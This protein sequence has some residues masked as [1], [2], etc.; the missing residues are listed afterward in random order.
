MNRMSLN[1]TVRA[2][3][4]LGVVACLALGTMLAHGAERAPARK[5]A[6]STPAPAAE[7][8]ARVIV[9]FRSDST[10]MRALAARP[11]SGP[12]PQQ[13]QALSARLGM[14]LRDGRELGARSQ[15]VFASGMSSAALAARLA[16]QADVEYAV[17]DGRQRALAAPNDPRYPA[18]QSTTPAV[19]QWY[20]R[21]YDP[22]TVSAINA[23]TAWAITTGSANVVVAMLDTGIRPEHPDLQG[24]LYPGYDFIHDA[25]TASDGDGRDADP[26][27]PGD[28]VTSNDVANGVPGCTND[29]IGPSSWHGTQTSGLVGAATNN[30]VGMASIGRN[31]MLLP[32]RVLGKCGGYD[33]DIQDA[34]RWA[35]GIA[36]TGVPANAHPAKVVN[37]SL[38]S[39]GACNA[40]YQDV[41]NQLTSLGVVVVAAAGNDGLAV[42]TPANC[43][44]VIAVAGA[45]HSGTKVGYSDLGPEVA[46]SA[47]AGN[48]VNSAGTCLYPLLTT[49]NTGTFNGPV[50]SIYTDGDNHISVGTSFSSPLVAGTAALM[51]SANPGLTPAQVRA[52]LAGSARPFPASDA[53]PIQRVTGGPLVPVSACEAPTSTA[54]DYECY[55]TTST[56]GA[57]LLNA[58]AAVTWAVLTP[59]ISVS[60]TSAQAGS[61][62]TLSDAGSQ[63][64]GGTTITGHQWEITGDTGLASFSG[65]TNA[66]TATL[67]L[68]AAGTV[69][70]SSTITDSVGR[71]S[72][73][74]ATINVAEPSGGGGGGGAFDPLWL[75]GVM[76]AAFVLSWSGRS[77]R[78]GP[79]RIRQSLSRAHRPSGR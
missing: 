14:V 76:L 27:D 64:F 77:L 68:S 1:R 66:S 53:A 46:I 54:Q 45:R 60:P 11:E 39:G 55:C 58:G 17:V 16:A 31:V 51:F 23:E 4:S 67:L 28:A 3:G 12:G 65:A 9:K 2:V 40:A 34:M 33:S 5:G 20:L 7:T 37:L 35:A 75:A 13:A 79:S 61:T 15:L 29:D 38:G 78:P 70:V 21:A 63:T 47:P 36:V 41:V 24:K 44:G 73:T 32:L 8:E 42:G 69:T 71:Q 48:C 30:G 6:A 43:S 74:T 52:M 10:L 56:C 62:V 72:T 19:G 50:S 18:G 25:P 26:S 22:T 59:N 57:G 49:S